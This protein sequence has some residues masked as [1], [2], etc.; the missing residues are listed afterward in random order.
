MQILRPEADPEAFFARLAGA[1]RAALLL[2]Y[3]GTLAPF[4]IDPAEARPY[5]GVAAALD[6]ILAQDDTRVVIVSGRWT[7]HLL[8]LLGLARTPEI[9]GSH[10]WERRYP[11]GR[12]EMARPVEAALRGLVEADGW[13]DAVHRLGGRSELKPACLAIHWRGLP[14]EVAGEIRQIVTE[15]WA[16]YARASGLELHAFDGGLELR[17]PGRDKGDAVRQLR[18]E[19]PDALLAYLGDDLTDEDAFRALS[20]TDL[21]V[22]ARPELRPTAAGL[23]LRPP[24]EVL[25]FLERWARVRT[26]ASGP[27]RAGG[28][29]P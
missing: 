9:W 1:P 7:R 24:D 21:A 8:P 6:A 27:A 23:W 14:D 17:V 18:A 19:M 29:R 28:E 13:I 4:R 2:D 5:P 26:A 25:A 3:D 16:L 10:G 22:L 12:T 11:D 15:N 20:G